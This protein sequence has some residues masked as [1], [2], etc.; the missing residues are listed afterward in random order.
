VRLA[1]P[2]DLV[3]RG[4]AGEL[5]QSLQPQRVLARRDSQL[6]CG[7]SRREPHRSTK[8]AKVPAV[9]EPPPTQATTWSGTALASS[10]AHWPRASSPMTRWKVRTIHGYGYGP[11]TEPAQ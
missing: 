8:P 3:N 4:T 5:T 9:L 6:G 1:Y 2:G 11:I 10:R 7:A